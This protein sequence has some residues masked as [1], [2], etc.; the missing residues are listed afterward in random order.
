MFSEYLGG[1]ALRKCP[2]RDVPISFET[3]GHCV[4]TGHPCSPD[5]KESACDTGDLGSILG[6][7]RA[8]GEGNGNAPQYSS[9]ENPMDRGPWQLQS[10]GSQRVGHDMSD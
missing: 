6:S 10:M 7:G 5:G 1:D 9:L 3:N 2:H 8:S 4:Y